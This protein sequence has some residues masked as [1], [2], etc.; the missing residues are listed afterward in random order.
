MEKL[1]VLIVDDEPG[2]RSGIE[3]ILRNYTV[4]FPFLDEDFSFEILEAATGEEA[5][6]IINKGSVDIII[7]TQIIAKGHH[8]PNLT[9]VGVI[10]AD[11][12]LSG[13]ELRASERV[14]QLLHQVA[15]R[16]GRAR[17]AGSGAYR[18]VGK[19]ET[20]S[21]HLSPVDAENSGRTSCAGA[22]RG[23]QSPPG[24]AASVSRA[25]SDQRHDHGWRH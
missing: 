9:C 25:G 14:Y 7:G 4:G 16:A 23:R 5:L 17:R 3:R 22:F 10:D 13:G 11:L 20:G 8:F 6:D 1:K 18:A 2:I 19:A 21:D 12:G 24:V 15:G